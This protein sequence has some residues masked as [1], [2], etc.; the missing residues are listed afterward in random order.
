MN[1]FLL[2]LLFLLF[3]VNFGYCSAPNRPT[4]YVAGTVIASSDV[5]TNE[6]TVYTYLQNGVDT[7]SAGS[8]NN[9]AV[10]SSAGIT[11][12][13]LNLTGGIVNSDVAS[14]AAIQ[15]SKLGVSGAI[16]NSDIAT[17]AGIVANKLNLTSPGPIG[18][19]SPNQGKFSLLNVGT[20]N[21]GDVLFDDGSS[22]I[23]LAPGTSGQF[24]QTQ[25]SGANPVWGSG[26][27]T[28]VS[29]TAVAAAANTGDIAITN[30][31]YNKVYFNLGALSGNDSLS[32]RL[33]NNSGANYSYQFNG[34]TTGGALTGGATGQT[35]IVMGT[36]ILADTTVFASGE[37]TIFPQTNA[38]IYISGVINYTDS[39]GS[40]HSSVNFSGQFNAVTVTSFRILTTGGATMTGNVFTYKYAQ[41]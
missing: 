33:T 24:L 20:T 5:N 22:F 14:G 2:F 41:S 1:K 12:A 23:R 39:A 34:R 26:G 37:M 25:G 28:F 36:S 11:Y 30:T 21:R 19:T 13:K 17:G 7:Y 10:S 4:S 29:K 16:I 15:Y 32:L 3:T 8:I 6:N 9:T 18:T 35:S 27:I 40:L 38:V 31:N